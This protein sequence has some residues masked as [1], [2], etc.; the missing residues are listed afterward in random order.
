VC[1]SFADENG[2]TRRQR[3]ARFGLPVEEPEP[4][5]QDF[6]YLLGWFWDLNAGRPPGFSGPEPLS[7]TELALWISLTGEIVRREEIRIIRSM[8]DAYLAAVARERVE[9]AERSPNRK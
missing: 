6:D 7:M 4:L 5:S 2:E 1:L 3:L 8:D 9:A